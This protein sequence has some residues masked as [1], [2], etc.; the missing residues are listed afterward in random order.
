MED[1][2][3]TDVMANYSGSALGC[4]A[5]EAYSTAEWPQ[6]IPAPSIC[7]ESRNHTSSFL[8]KGGAGGG[9]APQF[10]RT[11]LM[12]GALIRTQ[13]CTSPTLAWS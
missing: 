13:I 4:T 10:S 12:S 6:N 9:V 8:G 3:V 7:M 1:L 2:S 11:A 5:G